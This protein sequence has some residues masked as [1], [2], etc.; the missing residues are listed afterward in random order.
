MHMSGTP[1][2]VAVVPVRRNGRELEICLIRRRD[3]RKWGI[4]KGFI[5][6]GD[7][8][9]RAALNEA[10]EEAGLDGEIVGGAIGAYRY[11][12]WES[13]LTVAVYVMCVHG[14]ETKWHE[15]SFRERKWAS[16]EKADRLLAKHP[17]GPM[18]SDAIKHLTKARHK[19]STSGRRLQ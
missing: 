10:H 3:S 14:V 13:D 1:R 9:E 7:T 2:Q 8:P 19:Q 5:D 16:L 4:P 17:V 6:F 12:K 11:R 18:L 15:M